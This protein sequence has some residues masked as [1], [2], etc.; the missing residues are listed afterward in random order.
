LIAVIFQAVAL[1]PL[2]R[3]RPVFYRFHALVSNGIPEDRQATI[4]F[5]IS[6]DRAG[7]TVASFRKATY[8]VLSLR[9]CRQGVPDKEHK[10]HQYAS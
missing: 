4:G 2:H 8:I 6:A 3:P 7:Y 9:A 10:A 5:P 1:K